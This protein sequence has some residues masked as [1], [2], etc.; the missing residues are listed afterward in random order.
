MQ[1]FQRVGLLVVWGA[2]AWAA[3]A[4]RAGAADG[5]RLMLGTPKLGLTLDKGHNFAL[6]SIL[7]DGIEFG[8]G[9]QFP[10]FVLFDQ[11]GRE[12]PYPA[13]DARWQV[14][15]EAATATEVKLLYACSGLRV[16]VRYALAGGEIAISAIPKTEGTLKV[17]A[18]GDGGSLVI[19]PSNVPGAKQSGFVL[20]PF[21]CG[22]LIQFP[23]NGEYKK[24]THPQDWEYDA[25]FM[26]FGC[27]GR[28]LIVRCPQF[29]AVWTAGTEKLGGVYCLTGGLVA[30]YRPRRDNPG[31]YPFWNLPLVEPRID[32]RLVPVGDANGDGVFSWVD[33]GIAYRERFIRRNSLLDRSELGSMSGKIDM[34]GAHPNYT[35]LIEQIRA[36][37]WAPQRWWLVGPTVPVG[38]EFTY[39]CYSDAPHPSHNGPGGYDYFR[40]KRDCAAIGVKIG[41]HEMFQD[42]CAENAREWG[43]V[44]IRTQE[45]GEQVRTWSGKTPK[46]V[47]WDYSK[48]LA[49]MLGD[50]SFL[51][52]LDQHLRDWDVR[53]GDTWHWDCFTAFG[54]R[55]DFTPNHPTTHGADLRNRIAIL[56]YLQ[57]KGIHFGSEGLQEG[58]AEY[59]GFAWTA[60]TRPGEPS[61][62]AAGRPVPLVPVL[63]Q[64]R[65]YYYVTWY[66]A[67]NL[68]MGGKAGYEA[69]ALKPDEVKNAYFGSAV[70]WAKIADRTVKNMV[71]TA[72]GWRVEYA[73]GG[74]LAV[75]LAKM[76]PAMT[77]VLEL[78]GQRYTPET[79]PTS[80][81][82]VGARLVHR[83]SRQ[84]PFGGY[85]LIYP[86]NWK[87]P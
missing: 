71:E 35:E 11:K 76:G 16:E 42:V 9:G 50:G 46:G 1:R 26:G 87:R 31:P 2:V 48:A 64:G 65:T 43:K 69:D 22:E 33:L 28:G 14:T 6:S 73:E 77:F 3:L 8:S 63:F 82:G 75:D 79:P 5:G 4:D 27:N 81:W 56:Q 24:A 10:C 47:C 18:L 62:L 52:A 19:I 68:L 44:P 80:P 40:F 34:W 51:R 57:K 84:Y 15:V 83:A 7:V 49:P 53:P 20:R 32:I 41:L 55:S 29:G 30:D 59:C 54:G 21:G 85:E 78:D 37:D 38:N 39:P 61:P 66:P 25:S 72:S 36:V 74:S 17:R 86:K 23:A 60:Q 58:L 45:Y 12:E 13:G 70:F 67:W